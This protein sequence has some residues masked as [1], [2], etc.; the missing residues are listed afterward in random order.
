MRDLDWNLIRDFLAVARLGSL[1][2]AGA[3]AYRNASTIG[4]RIALL[5]DQLGVT[6]FAKSK[7]GYLL[8]DD[9]EEL[10]ARAERMEEAAN[11]VERGAA[12]RQAVSGHVT[13]A[14][15][16]NLANML[17]LP[18]L[19]R[20]VATHP[21]LVPEVI[22]DIRSANLN[23]READ[24]ALRL[25]RPTQGNVVIRKIGVQ[26]YGVYGRPDIVREAEKTG[27]RRIV[28]WSETYADLPAA[29]WAAGVLQGM[30]PALVTSSLY[31]QYV[32]VR[33]GM[34]LA[35]L[36]C[37]MGDRTKDLVRLNSDADAVSQDLWLVLHADLAASARVRAVAEFVF[38][39]VERNRAF[40][41]GTG[42]RYL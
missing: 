35:M 37:F 38:D 36:P 32:A 12:D 15:A 13:L 18:D 8:T 1:S 39:I 17:I 24:L 6:L 27:P 20:L 21:S 22:T 31:A 26:R 41:E 25:T 16:E 4:R 19:P 34:G 3:R 14:T 2:R 29:Q 10:L 23:R 30:S 40:L 42:S 28:T 5:E 7:T 9:G 33:A 11:A